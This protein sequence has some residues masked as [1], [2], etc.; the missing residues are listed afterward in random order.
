MPVVRWRTRPTGCVCGHPTL[1][2]SIYCN[3]LHEQTAISRVLCMVDHE[4]GFCSEGT[5]TWYISTANAVFIFVV[6]LCLI[7][8]APFLLRK[9]LARPSPMHALTLFRASG[10]AL[11]TPLL[12]V[13]LR[14]TLVTRATHV[15]R[16]VSST[17]SSSLENTCTASN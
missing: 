17:F 5:V 1:R 3:V 8:I 15:P 16:D 6:L 12:I 7:A 10:P 13:G 14:R 4:Q 2:T 9:T 11:T